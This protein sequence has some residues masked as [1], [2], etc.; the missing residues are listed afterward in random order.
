[1]SL[2]RPTKTHQR[3]RRRPCRRPHCQK[4]YYSVVEK[5]Q[6]IYGKEVIPTLQ[7]P[8]KEYC[9]GDIKGDLAGD[10]IATEI[11]FFFRKNAE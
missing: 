4:K 7:D 11:M 9:V 2:E 5:S 1:M 3:H 8:Q 10:I 6:K